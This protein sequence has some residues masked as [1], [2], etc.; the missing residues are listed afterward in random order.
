MSVGGGFDRRRNVRETREEASHFSASSA[1]SSGE[2]SGE[3]KPL[4]RLG[5]GY[6]LPLGGQISV[7]P[8]V[9]FDYADSTPIV[10]YGATVGFGF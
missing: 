4:F 1:A 7:T 2:S 9:A 6:S 8:T 5:V 3:R 10:V